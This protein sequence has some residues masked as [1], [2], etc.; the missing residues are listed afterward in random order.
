MQLVSSSEPHTNIKISL[1]F[2]AE[3][4]IVRLT[5]NK[6]KQILHSFVTV[7]LHNQIST[8]WNPNFKNNPL[9]I[10]PKTLQLI[11]PKL[12]YLLR[13]LTLWL[14]LYF[15]LPRHLKERRLSS[16]RLRLWL[17]LGRRLG[18]GSFLFFLAGFPVFF[19]L[20]FSQ[21]FVFSHFDVFFDGFG[22]EVVEITPTLFNVLFGYIWLVKFILYAFTLALFYFFS[23]F[24]HRFCKVN[25]P[26]YLNIVQV[27][28][29]ANN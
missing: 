20:L 3:T 27:V 7:N 28:D 12:F 8:I 1:Q 11:G 26:N 29:S 13:R 25:P 18:F 5:P 17:R 9:T 19:F 15:L 22:P 23:D 4:K 14:R 16:V 10:L 6:I 21:F 2:I 24:L